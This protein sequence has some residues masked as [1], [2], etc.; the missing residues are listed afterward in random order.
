MAKVVNPLFTWRRAML[1]SDLKPT[2]KHVLLTLSCYMNEFG[3]E[4]FPSIDTLKGTQA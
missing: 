4:C 2:T 3:K 1:N